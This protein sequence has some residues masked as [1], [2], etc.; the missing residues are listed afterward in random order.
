MR[1]LNCSLQN[2]EREW[3]NKKIIF[4]GAGSWLNTVKHTEVMKYKNCFLCV[5]DNGKRGKISLEDIELDIVSPEYLIGK[6]DIIVVLTS[7][8]YMYD[9]YIQLKSLNLDDSIIVYSLPFMI[10]ESQETIDPYILEKVI[11]KPENNV[12]PRT[13][14]GFWFS[15]EEKPDSY[16]RCVDSWYTILKDYE[17]IEWN[18]DNYPIHSH[19]FLEK[20][21]KCEAWAFATDFARLDVL[22]R[23][24][25]IY[26]DMDVKVIKTFD[27]LLDNEAVLS[28]ANYAQVDL[29]FLA[30]KK[31]NSIIGA[32][33]EIYNNVAI[34]N[35]R[36]EFMNF[37]QPNLVRDILHELGVKFNGSLQILEGGAVFP[38][39]FFMP[40]D[41][42]LFREYSITEHTYC[43]HMDNFGWGYDGENKRTK[44]IRD[45]NTL[46]SMIEKC[47]IS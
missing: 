42:T 12:I 26:L 35:S 24:G 20:A 46:W 3:G 15:G 32:L 1:L 37:H 25:G 40:M 21:I 29:A 16:K 2:I 34:P 7:P 19:P 8:L 39:S 36:K 27:D 14:H 47:S 30:A 5:I 22:S 44:K 13:I 43:V 18:Q 4:F 38:P 17:I 11:N 23:Y 31:G 33:R 28:F 10:L 41:T 45:N 6:T 9:M